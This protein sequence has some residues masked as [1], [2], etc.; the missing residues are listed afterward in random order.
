MLQ[1]FDPNMPVLA[2]VRR[3][4]QQFEATITLGARPRSFGARCGSDAKSLRRDGF[5]SIFCHD[6]TLE[7]DKCG[8]PV[9][10]LDGNWLGVNIARNSRVRTFAIPC[11]CRCQFVRKY[12]DE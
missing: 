3:N 10:D 7:P 2:K 8:G 5:P 11:G 12:R 1:T 4:S 9:V 6:A